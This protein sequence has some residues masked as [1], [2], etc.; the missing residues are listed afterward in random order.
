MTTHTR[1]TPRGLAWALCGLLAGLG[2]SACYEEAE[3][4][5]GERFEGRLFQVYDGREGIYP[6]QS[7]LEDPLNP[8]RNAPPFGDEKWDIESS[9]AGPVLK[10]YSW[11]S[12]LATQPTGE[13]Q[14]YTAASLAQIYEQGL[15]PDEELTDVRDM[16]VAA[17]QSM[18]DNFPDAVT[19]DATGQFAYPLATP[20]YQAMVELG[21]PIDGGWVLVETSSGPTAV[22]P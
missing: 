2:T 4:V 10:F 16:A 9:N 6:S 11:A 7:V 21:G 18:L 1:S 20:A 13:N 12:V 5:Y 17:Y 14:F 3:Y 8:F 22:Q 19:F 15:A